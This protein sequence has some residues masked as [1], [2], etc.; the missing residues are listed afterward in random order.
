MPSYIPIELTVIEEDGF[1]LMIAVEING[2]PA[3]MLLDTGASR[4]VFD[5]ERISRF[6]TDNKPNFEV[7]EKLSTGLGTR[8]MQSQAVYLKEF[9]IG[10][11][12]IREYPAVVLDMSHVNLSYSEL[13]LPPIDGVIGSDILMKYAAVINYGKM[14]M[15]INKRRVPMRSIP[16]DKVKPGN[17][18][19]EEGGF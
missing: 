6:F 17:H 15:R 9:K 1:H 16:K 5:L 10:E 19:H 13:D 7:N 8:D 18:N 4:S 3:R 14:Q 2:L 11:L 12:C